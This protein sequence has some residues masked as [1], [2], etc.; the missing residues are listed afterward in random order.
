MG[1]AFGT[2]WKALLRNSTF[3][4]STLGLNVVTC[5]PVGAVQSWCAAY[6]VRQ[7]WLVQ[8]K[9][10]DV[11]VERRENKRGEEGG[12]EERGG[13]IWFGGHDDALRSSTA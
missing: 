1:L 5:S 9:S 6:C 2:L 7:I 4:S 10:E 13:L 8:V 11:M 3:L 12:E